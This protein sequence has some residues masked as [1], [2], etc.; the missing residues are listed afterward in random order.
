MLQAMV[1]L[2]ATSAK[3]IR[4]NGKIAFK[5]A[6]SPNATDLKV[7]DIT[8]MASRATRVSGFLDLWVRYAQAEDVLQF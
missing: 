8:G 3:L 2:S 1:R 5:F 7:G 6:V 4:T